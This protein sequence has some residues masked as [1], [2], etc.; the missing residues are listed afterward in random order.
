[1][2]RKSLQN[3]AKVK[4]A[5]STSR[6]STDYASCKE[7]IPIHVDAASASSQHSVCRP[8]SDKTP[9][10]RFD[11]KKAV[12]QISWPSS[13]LDERPNL[14]VRSNNHW[15]MGP[16]IGTTMRKHCCTGAAA[17]VFRCWCCIK[18]KHGECLIQSTKSTVSDRELLVSFC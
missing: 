16:T 3:Y 11:H 7:N 1:M 6:G 17:S 18:Q 2:L 10:S 8:D 12:A 4:A 9:T 15:L 14:T 5:S 13:P